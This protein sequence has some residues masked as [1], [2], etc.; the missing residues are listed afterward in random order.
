[1][2]FA[3]VIGRSPT[4]AAGASWTSRTTDALWAARAYH[5]TVI[6]AAGAIYIIGGFSGGSTS[7]K[8]VW[9]STDRGADRTRGVLDGYLRVLTGYFVVQGVLHGTLGVFRGSC[10]GTS[11]LL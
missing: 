1:M 9:V 4:C 8:D 3:L 10:P 5:T 6:D 2:R 11:G 7:Y